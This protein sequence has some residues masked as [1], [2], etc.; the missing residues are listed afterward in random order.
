MPAGWQTVTLG[1]VGQYINGKA[2]KRSEWSRT[3]L[4]IIRIQN[5]NR[6]KSE[7]NY[8][9]TIIEQKY[10]VHKG[11]LLFAWSGTPDTSFGAHIWKGETGLLNQHI[12]RIEIDKAIIDQ[13]YYL[14][15]LNHKVKE[16]VSKAHGTA[17]L[18]HITKRKFEES[19]I[20]LPPLA[21]QQAIVAKIEELFSELDKG[22]ESIKLAQQQLKTY[23]QSVLKAAFEGA[24]TPG[25]SPAGRGEQEG[26]PA[27]WK[28]VLIEDV[29][30]TFSGY[31]FKSGDFKDSGHYQVIRMG[32]VRPGQL[33]LDEK[34]VFLSKIDKATLAKTELSIGDVIITLTGT[35]Q[36]R[37]YGFTTLIDREKLLLNQRISAIRFNQDY[38]PKFFLYFSWTDNFKDQFFANETGNVGQGNVGVN[39]VTKTRIPLPPLAEQQA[40][41]AAIES[42]LS[43]ADSLEATL[44]QSLEKA[45]ALRQSVLKKAFEGRLVK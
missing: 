5:L 41:V 9:N 2:F 34:P 40:I 20:A 37:D 43:V 12:F 18:A 1:D 6:E 30:R 35:R 26:L 38:D 3:G 17:G 27:G 39:A 4:P 7:F 29:A 25:P 11:D 33:R 42:R 19:E 28:W 21:T 45:E 10:Y 15:V 44:A 31:A 36:K 22:I 23:R 13:Q 24:L 16:F 32:N 8:C 14:H